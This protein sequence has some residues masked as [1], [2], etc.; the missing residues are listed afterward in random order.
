[1]SELKRGS[2]NLMAL[3][4]DTVVIGF[5]NFVDQF[6]STQKGKQAADARGT[7]ALGL[8]GGVAAGGIEQPPEVAVPEAVVANSPREMAWSKGL[9]K[10]NLAGSGRDLT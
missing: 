1:M 5:E 9:T 3:S 4:R 8:L 7:L 2:H 6:V 10:N